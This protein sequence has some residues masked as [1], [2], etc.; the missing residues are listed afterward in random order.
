MS[1][2]T[3]DAVLDQHLLTAVFQPIVATDSLHVVGYE[4][5]I[6]GPAGTPLATPSA[7]FAAARSAGRHFELQVECVR[8]IWTRFAQLALPG[9][10]FVNFCA[11]TLLAPAP[12]RRILLDAI[13]DVGLDPQRV[14]IEITED[15]EVA[16]FRRL[17]R[18]GGQLRRHGFGLAIDDLG[19]GFASLRMWLELQPT[20]VKI[21]ISFVKGV[22]RDPIKQ[23]FM[24]S[25]QDIA[26]ACDTRLIAEGIETATELAFVRDLGIDYGQGFY[27][28]HPAALPR[29][30]VP[31]NEFL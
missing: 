14:V 8:V 30:D 9:K 29:R 11:A 3:I 22:E 24:R 26:R 5:L 7:L 17:R 13:A 27:I 25:I 10:L 12:Q 15:Q 16:D 21:D 4:G 19:A 2:P 28:A 31:F 6:R 1:S 18:I 20:Y 23:A